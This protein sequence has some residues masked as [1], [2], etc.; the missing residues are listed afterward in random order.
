MK[1]NSHPL[2]VPGQMRPTHAWVLLALAFLLTG[3]AARALA[4]N[5]AES[6]NP[7]APATV[8]TN[9]PETVAATPEA[10]TEP[11]AGP[12]AE[13]AGSG[14]TSESSTNGLRLNFHNA[15]IDLV[16]SYLSDAAG[17]IIQLDTNVRG[18]V[19][20]ISSHPMTKDEAV[21]LLNSVL[22]KNG[23]AAIRSGRTLKIMDKNTAKSSN[24]PVRVSNDPD[25]VPDNDEMVTQIVPVRFVEAQQ[26]VSDLSPFVSPQATI[27]A[28]QAGNS[29][30]VTDTQA[31]IRHL[32]E[33]IKAIDSSAEDVTELRVFHLKYADPT[34]MASLLTSLF[35]DQNA[36]GVQVPIRFGGRGFP[37][38]RFAAA[39]AN[40]N[41][42]NSQTDRIKK[43]NQ[44]V[45][46]AD[47]RTS[48]VV[49][50]ATKDLM[51]QIAD[52]VKD[53]DFKSDKEQMV[54]VFHMNNADVQEILPLLQ[55]MFGGNTS[56][57]GAAAGATGA[58]AN[59]ALMNRNEQY[60]Q[61][62]TSGT[63][64]GFG[65]GLGNGLGTGRGV[66]GGPGAF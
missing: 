54:K 49:V 39:A 40:N 41:T 8:T 62:T 7:P 5:T 28:N 36:T 30:V 66:G 43:R 15:P 64:S 20:V 33:I 17:F 31:N 11:G 63:M 65:N 19:S 29:I 3:L 26:L 50:T 47:P 18:T 22:N 37:F 14:G 23:Y 52:M 35:P 6:T 60:Q 13:A 4:Q 12:V 16:L 1:T 59:S 44:V 25:S 24:N 2:P 57:S 51:D 27:V 10:A 9:G 34:E 55:N 58:S 48:S 56:R 45:A 46:V 21:E 61:S 42:S 53:L 32:L 38:G